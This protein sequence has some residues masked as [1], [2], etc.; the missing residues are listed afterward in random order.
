AYNSSWPIVSAQ[1][2]AGYQ[3]IAFDY[4][5]LF[6]KSWNQTFIATTYTPL[7][8][9]VGA[10]AR[11][12][13]VT[14]GSPLLAIQPSYY[15]IT[16]PFVESLP[17][18]AQT[19]SLFVSAA[20]FFNIYGGGSG[21]GCS[22]NNCWNDQNS[23]RSFTINTVAQG[24]MANSVQ[25]TILGEIY[26][27]GASATGSDLTSLGLQILRN[28]NMLTYHVQPSRDVYS[29]FAS[30]MNDIILVVIDFKMICPYP[31]YCMPVYRHDV[32]IPKLFINE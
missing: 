4:L 8:L 17:F 25:H 2:P 24:A 7:Q 13:N 6:Y 30:A 12:Q 20:R 11:A 28:Y 10:F 26:D 9:F 29:Q 3:K 21:I 31:M 27:L 23:I 19:L 22:N 32:G 15:N 1:T 16:L 5:T 14:K 18:D